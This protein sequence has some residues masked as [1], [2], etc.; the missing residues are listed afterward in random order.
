M[1]TDEAIAR[2]ALR[3]IP[4]RETAENIGIKQ[5]SPGTTVLL[6]MYAEGG[7]VSTGDVHYA[8]GDC[9]FAGECPAPAGHLHVISWFH[10]TK[11]HTAAA[12][13]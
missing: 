1:P 8:Q 13:P 4:P 2:E 12:T 9:E 3:T 10:R 5:L 11:S 7:L 6:P